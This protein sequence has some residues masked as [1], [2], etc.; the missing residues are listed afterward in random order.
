MYKSEIID[1]IQ[2]MRNASDGFVSNIVYGK[3]KS[4]ED[5]PVEIE[6][7][8]LVVYN[9]EMYRTTV[10]YAAR[11]INELQML[12]M[13]LPS[14]IYLE[15]F[16]SKEKD[17]GEFFLKQCGFD[18]YAKYVRITTSYL[19]NPYCVE[20]EG[21]RK[22]LADLYDPMMGE[23]P[24]EADA[25]EIFRLCSEKFDPIIDDTFSI[26]EWKEIIRKNECLVVRENNKIVTLYK[27]RLEGKKLY[28][29]TSINDGPA[30]F[31]YNLE[32]K[33]FEQYWEEGIRVYYAWINIKNT[34]ALKHG[35]RND[36][37]IV[38]HKG[39]LYNSIYKK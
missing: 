20:E 9:K 23:F 5:Y 2:E 22:L 31:L 21:R 19:G 10:F 29:N 14:G 38:K 1:K 26:D 6:E 37:K 25:E 12:L 7:G 36:K 28:S 8:A 27:W 11:N 32:R 34:R 18:S 17:E 39:F 24:D 4:D 3:M 15:T 16:H 33:V 13:K 35:P 30:N